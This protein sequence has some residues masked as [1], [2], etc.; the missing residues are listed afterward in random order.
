[1][2]RGTN[3]A[4]IP[5]PYVEQMHCGGP[6]FTEIPELTVYGSACTEEQLSPVLER[7]EELKLHF[8]LITEGNAIQDGPYVILPIRGNHVKPGL[9]TAIL[10]RRKEKPCFMLW[11]PAFTRTT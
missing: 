11:I 1:M 9:R 2:W 6:R 7:A 3:E 5:L 4:Q 8:H 10:W